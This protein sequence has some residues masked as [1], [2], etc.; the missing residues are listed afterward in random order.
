MTVLTP[1]TATKKKKKNIYLTFLKRSPRCT[2]LI[3]YARLADGDD[4]S[5]HRHD[6][7]DVLDGE[8]VF[9]DDREDD[10]DGE[11]RAREERHVPEGRARSKCTSLLYLSRLLYF[12]LVT[13][14]NLKKVPLLVTMYI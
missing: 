7:D 2:D 3:G 4:E 6:A 12:I 5:E 14:Y 10:E 9:V 8:D 11:H 13:K 1:R